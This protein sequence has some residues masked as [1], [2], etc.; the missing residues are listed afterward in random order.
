MILYIK[1]VVSGGQTGAD[2]AGLEAAKEAGIT[3]GGYCPK[4]Y[5][6]EEGYDKSLKGFGLVQT[7]T[8]DYKER[9][10]LNVKHSDGTVIFSNKD[11]AG[12]IFG[13]GTLFTIKIVKELTKPL[14]INPGSKTF[15]EWV[16]KNDIRILNVAGN[17]DNQNESIYKCVYKFLKESLLIPANA[18]I[19]I[20]KVSVKKL[21]KEKQK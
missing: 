12:R 2:R 19:V 11:K 21:H 13:I 6:T 7:K 4:N 9:T 18:E 17:R 14:I 1:K 16:V 5:L 3:T 20:Q 8:E 10:V 15:K